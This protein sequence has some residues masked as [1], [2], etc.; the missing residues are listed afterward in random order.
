MQ[1]NIRFNLLNFNITIMKTKKMLILICVF[2]GII[3][4]SCSQTEELDLLENTVRVE[5]NTDLLLRSFNSTSNWENLNQVTLPGVNGKTVATPWSTG[6]VP[7]GI[8]DDIRTDIKS[9]DGWTCVYS[10]IDDTSTPNNFIVFYNRF[11]GILKGFYYWDGAGQQNTALWDISFNSSHKLFNGLDHFTMPLQST[12]TPT[13]STVFNTVKSQT[14]GFERDS[15]N[16]FQTYLTYDPSYS[17]TNLRMN[18]GARNVNDF[19]FE[20]SG[21]YNSASN[22]SIISTSS[23][24]NSSLSNIKNGIITQTGKAGKEWIQDKISKGVIGAAGANIIAGGVPAI[25][26]SGVNLIFGSFFGKSK[27]TPTTETLQFTT[28][29][30]IK[31]NI[32]GTFQTSGLIQPLS[33]IKLNS[34]ERLGN[35]NLE[36][37][38]TLVFDDLVYPEISFSESGTEEKLRQFVR[39][40]EIEDVNVVFNDKLKQEF[41]DRYEVS[42]QILYYAKFNGDD[43][44]N[45]HNP[46]Y[47]N[48]DSTIFTYVLF[49][50]K[51]DSNNI[52]NKFWYLGGNKIYYKSYARPIV[53]NG[54]QKPHYQIKENNYWGLPYNEKPGFVVK[55]T[56]KIYPKSPTF[57]STPIITTKTFIPKQT[58]RTLQYAGW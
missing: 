43:C 1:T 58:V 29:G 17:L 24:S 9:A 11:T 5:N 18:I 47:P 10:G 34:Q 56:V 51:D 45:W 15:W 27:P 31:A 35:W 40:I 23:S 14:K 46:L 49:E 41:I 38:P 37:Q 19:R 33:N 50:D 6:T 55:V 13:Y 4:P 52:Q 26:S 32:D 53:I 30:S 54:Y 3:L 7:T 2:C 22:G 44:W 16:C 28:K 36:K 21:E 57:D 8:P 48:F 42:K 20:M 12:T 39:K 25:V